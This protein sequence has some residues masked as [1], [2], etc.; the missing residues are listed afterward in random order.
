MG[1]KP[2]RKPFEEMTLE[3]LE[4]AAREDEEMLVRVEAAVVQ[5]QAVLDNK[6][7]W[8]DLTVVA[9]ELNDVLDDL[10]DQI[11]EIEG[12]FRERKIRPGWVPMT[13]QPETYP[14]LPRGLLAKSGA[15]IWDGTY[16]IWESDD[17]AQ[18]GRLLHA[19][20]AVRATAVSYLNPLW[21]ELNRPRLI[22]EGEART[23]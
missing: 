13:Y 15:L 11:S 18:V 2:K 12:K 17:H 8:E 14:R 7:L 23:P 3:E 10:N 21:E 4:Q 16:L 19:S 22:P 9:M 5:V 6:K 1:K 20:K